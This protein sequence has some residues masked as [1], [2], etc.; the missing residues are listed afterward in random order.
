MRIACHTLDSLGRVI[1]GTLTPQATELNKKPQNK[2]HEC[3]APQAWI[4]SL[5]ARADTHSW[6]WKYFKF[7]HATRTHSKIVIKQAKLIPARRHSWNLQ[8]AQ[9]F[10]G[11]ESHAR[12]NR[13]NGL[14]KVLNVCVQSPRHLCVSAIGRAVL[15]NWLINPSIFAWFIAKNEATN[16]TKNRS[17]FAPLDLSIYLKVSKREEKIKRQFFTQLSRQ[18]KSIL[19]SL[20]ER[21]ASATQVMALIKI[22]HSWS[23]T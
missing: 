20:F 23:D 12:S 22:C 17:I 7:L 9:V 19:W 10:Y 8:R 2:W 11:N 16:V 5:N 3:G 4:K 1:A 15:F 14:W 6:V 13:L 21:D 18:T